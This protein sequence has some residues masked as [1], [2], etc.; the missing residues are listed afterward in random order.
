M[1][2]AVREVQLA[3]AVHV[4][5]NRHFV[6]PSRRVRARPR[7]GDSR[8]V[9]GEHFVHGWDACI[10]RA[11]TGRAAAGAHGQEQQHAK[12]PKATTHGRHCTVYA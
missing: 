11:F 9:D 6:D 8:K 3:A 7:S 1:I 5:E 12:N 2:E 10:A 4:G